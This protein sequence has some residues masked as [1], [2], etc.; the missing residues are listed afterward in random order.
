MEDIES[1]VKQGHIVV[2][3]LVLLIIFIY[4]IISV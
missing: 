4:S 1:E 2:C 3:S